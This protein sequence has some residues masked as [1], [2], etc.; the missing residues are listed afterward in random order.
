MRAVFSPSA[1]QSSRQ[2]RPG[3]VL[4]AVLIVIVVLTLAAYRF[5]DSML[6]EYRAAVR[7]SDLA[8]ARA[9]A[10]SGVHYVSALLADPEAMELYFGGEPT[11]DNADLFANVVVHSDPDKPAREARFSIIS[12]AMTGPGSF[13]QRYALTDESGKLNINALIAQD[14]KG[15]VLYNA[16]LKLPNM[17]PDI[18]DAIVDWVDAD[19]V[20]R[21]TGAESDYYQALGNPYRA[22]NGPLNSIDELLL[23]KGVTPQLLYGSDQNQSGSSDRGLTDYI[24]VYGREVTA[25]ANGLL[26]VFI[27]GDEVGP[28]YDALLASGIDEE[29]AAYI[30]AAKLFG[31]TRLDENGNPTGRN[32]SQKV[33]PAGLD[34]LIQAVE[35]KVA[36]ATNAGRALNSIIDLKD[37]RVTLPKAAGQQNSTAYYS[38]LNNPE[39]LSALLPVLLSRVSTK[40]AVEMVPRL[41]VNTAPQEVI[42]GLPGLEEEDVSAILSAREGITPGSLEATTGA[43]LVTAAGL[44]RDKFKKIEKYVTGSTMIYRVQSVGYIAG[45]PSARIEAVIDT[46]F[47]APRIVYFRDLGELDSPRAFPQNNKP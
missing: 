27:N 36:N 19:S 34:Q 20:A 39:R 13:E 16:L 33:D 37:T 25:D 18:A 7:T 30:M 46:N 35:D 22:K 15:E 5:T 2:Q 1:L 12:I 8:Q 17:T 38:P 42:Q 11:F 28:I 45:G 32:A 21:T 23:V 44:T 6:G 9:A 26:K 14:K 43:W 24:T 4:L 10:L 47:G 29:M 41:N 40:D 3:Y 31:T